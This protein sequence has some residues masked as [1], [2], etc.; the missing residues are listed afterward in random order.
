MNRYDAVL[1]WVPN[2][3]AWQVLLLSERARGQFGPEPQLQLG[4]TAPLLEQLNR[5]LSC[6]VI[7]GQ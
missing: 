1:A 3:A 4:E 7:A 6:M 2:D 5:E